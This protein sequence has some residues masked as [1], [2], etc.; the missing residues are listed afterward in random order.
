MSSTNNQKTLENKRIDE[1]RIAMSFH[2]YRLWYYGAVY[3]LIILIL[4]LKF[5]K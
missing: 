3:I 5:T 4:S 2:S 1:P